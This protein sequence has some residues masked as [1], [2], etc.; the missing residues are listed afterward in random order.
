MDIRAVVGDIARIKA[1]A[2]VVNFFEGMKH[3]EG[4]TANIDKALGGAISR[5]IS[6][7]EIKG[8]LNEVTIVHSLGKLPASRVAVA[9][10][11]SWA[12]VLRSR[13]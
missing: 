4:D 9:G 1:S 6:Q 8:K 7:G 13:L 12:A 11:V 2:I 10:L 3:P 5:L